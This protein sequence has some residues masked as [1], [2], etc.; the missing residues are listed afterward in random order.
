MVSSSLNKII[1]YNLFEKTHGDVIAQLTNLLGDEISIK[2]IPY[3]K[4]I[5][6]EIC[7]SGSD[8]S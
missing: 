4:G 3:K 2:D 1:Y 5:N 7:D 8:M 6:E